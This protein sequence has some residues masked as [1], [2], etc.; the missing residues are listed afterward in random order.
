MARKVNKFELSDS[1]RVFLQSFSQSGTAKAREIKRSLALLQL[2][3]G[4]SIGEL[5]GNLGMGIGTLYSLRRKYNSEGLESALHDK[6]RSGRPPEVLSMDKAKITA[7][8]CSE[9]P[10]GRVRWTL[11]L[12][13]DKA[14]ELGYVTKGDISHTWVGDILKKQT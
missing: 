12:L 13:A 1:D 11:R 4:K 8:A 7:L 9:A 3:A 5:A 2:D 10:T 6:P 14:V